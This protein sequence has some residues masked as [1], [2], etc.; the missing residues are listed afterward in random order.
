MSEQAD[1]RVDEDLLAL[2]R[3]VLAESGFVAELVH[4]ETVL[5]AEN[6]F[7]IV[8]LAA[9]PTLADLL[10]AEA[11]VESFLRARIAEANVGP[12][13]WDAYLVLLTQDSSQSPGRNYQRLF[14]INYDTHEFRRIA[15][16]GVG[17]TFREVRSALTPFV[18]PLRLDEAG[19]SVD[20]LDSLPAALNRHGIDMDIAERAVDIF[21]QGGRLD[22][23]L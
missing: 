13:V 11:T 12:K 17:P 6:Q 1:F 23:A 19:L 4:S 10:A 14:E 2:A 15:R 20:P 3:T 9:T 5:L 8:A 22:D 18:E 21:R 16:V 7:A